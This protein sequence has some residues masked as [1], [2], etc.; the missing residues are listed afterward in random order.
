MAQNL[1]SKEIV[2]IEGLAKSNMFQIETI[3]SRLVK[4]GVITKQECRN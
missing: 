2:T 4:N 3:L 1:N